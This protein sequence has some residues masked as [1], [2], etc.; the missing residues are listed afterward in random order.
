MLQ[1]SLLFP[2]QPCKV[3]DEVAETQVEAPCT[4]MVHLEWDY[5]KKSPNPQLV[6]TKQE[7]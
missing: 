1:L 3:V 6:L 5:L 2:W 4:P 7:I